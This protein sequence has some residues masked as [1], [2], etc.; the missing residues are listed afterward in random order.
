MKTSLICG[1]LLFSTL[2][3]ASTV[4]ETIEKIEFKKNAKCERISIGTNYCL[5]LY[6]LRS[7]KLVCVSNSG[8]FKVKLKVKTRT[9][10]NG[11][12]DESVTKIKYL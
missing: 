2:C 6:C 9:L 10:S 8:S 1:L 7:D 3:F 11:Q 12:S 4:S 5:N